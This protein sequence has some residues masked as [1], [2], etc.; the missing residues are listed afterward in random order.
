MAGTIS[1]DGVVLCPSAQADWQ[2]SVA[3]GVVGGS[4]N[5]PRVTHFPNALPVTKDL[6][7]L[8]KPVTPGEVFRFAAPCRCGGCV[9]FNEE[10]CHLATRIVQLLPSVS[11][12]LP[13]CS[14]RPYCRWWRQEGKA[15]CLRC[16]QVI[17][18]NYNPSM[19]MQ[20]IAT[21][22]LSTPHAVRTE[23]NCVGYQ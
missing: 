17:T 23:A 11:E 15:A 12:R 21:P 18:D 13:R 7:A 1:S 10:E 22:S 2:G 6:I 19:L 20:E 4:A 5:E 16:P 9:H 8:T 3:I 14:I